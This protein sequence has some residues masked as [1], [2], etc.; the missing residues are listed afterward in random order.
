MDKFGIFNIL[1]LLLGNKASENSNTSASS[2]PLQDL[3]K[4]LTATK[5]DQQKNQSQQGE[6]A[7]KPDPLAVP[8]PLQSSMVS[9]MTN[10]D[11]LIKRVKEK[12][13]TN[14]D[15]LK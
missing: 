2:A 5:N 7:K 4:N 1:N 14:P 12:A 11:Q 13:Q 6:Q 8:L 3:I 9:T 10:H 15:K